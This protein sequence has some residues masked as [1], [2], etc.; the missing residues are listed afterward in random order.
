MERRRVKQEASLEER[1]AGQARRL[2][3]EA[4]MLPPGGERDGLIRRARQT[5]IAWHI[6]EWLNS[7]GL[8]PPK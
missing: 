7:P 5:E 4:E 8:A 3:D 2:R 1:L 6:N